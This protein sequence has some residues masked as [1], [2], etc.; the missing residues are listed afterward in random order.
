MTTTVVLSCTDSQYGPIF[1]K[2]LAWIT[3][4]TEAFEVATDGVAAW[5]LVF[6]EMVMAL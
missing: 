3:Y 4:R 1:W 2:D 5:Q 6:L